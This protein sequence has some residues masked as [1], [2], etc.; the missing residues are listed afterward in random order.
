MRVTT[1]LLSLAILLAQINSQ[2]SAEEI[3]I[4]S[5]DSDLTIE[6]I[7]LIIDDIEYQASDKAKQARH[8]N[9]FLR[10]VYKE[11]SHE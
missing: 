5:A 10:S 2:A 6:D 4:T 11:Q 7:A 1:L 8:A 9:D 3:T